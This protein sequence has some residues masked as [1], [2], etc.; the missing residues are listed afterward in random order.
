[1][2]SP[3]TL[4]APFA[5]TYDGASAV[6]GASDHLRRRAIEAIQGVKAR[7]NAAVKIFM[8]ILRS[9]FRVQSAECRVQRARESC[10]PSSEAPCRAS[11]EGCASTAWSGAAPKKLRSR[12]AGGATRPVESLFIWSELQRFGREAT[13]ASIPEH[14]AG[15]QFDRH[16]K[17]RSAHLHTPAPA[18]DH[19]PTTS[20]TRHRC[21]WERLEGRIPPGRYRSRTA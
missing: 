4:P 9:C 8:G 13:L 19:L 16:P 7:T 10:T 14:S 3:G 1:M 17:R 20:R 11:A 21:W 12:G 2:V 15:R 6:L 5:M 18:A